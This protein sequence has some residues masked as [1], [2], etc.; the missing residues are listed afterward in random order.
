MN[1]LRI[2]AALLLCPIGGVLSLVLLSKHYG[3]PL[4]GEAVL[5]AC[6]QSGGCDIVDQSRFA[7][8]LGIPLAAWG[9]FF[10]GALVALLAPLLASD[11][12]GETDSE[13]SVAFC[14]FAAAVAIDAFL[15]GLQFVVIKAFCKFCIATYAVNLLGLALLWPFRSL[16]QLLGYFTAGPR[17]RAMAAWTVGVLA[18]AAAALAGNAALETRKALASA[19]ILGLPLAPAPAPAQ[20]SEAGSIEQQLSAARAEAKKWKDT[21][22]DEKRLQVY[23]TQ[24]AR[25]DFNQAPV[26]DLDLRRTPAKGKAGAPIKV[27]TY[28]DFMCPFCRD[29]ALGLR[30]YLPSSG[31]QVELYYKNF[32]LDT[33]CNSQIGRTVHQGACELA[34]G[35]ICA[36]ESGRFW[37][38]HDRVFAESWQS[39]VAKR[40]D[41]LRLGASAGLDAAKLGA[42]VAASS[43]RGRLTA[44]IEEGFRIGVGSTPTV[45][46]NGRRLGSSNVFLLAVDE[47]RKR[48]NL[49]NAATAAPTTK[50]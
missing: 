49:A 47:E 45:V 33:T 4:L 27:V 29:L 30:N 8:F 6:G 38:Y 9:L 48:L 41:V 44:E 2:G 21:L 13:L 36:A 19:S 26:L 31:D 25:N 17:R 35:G 46:V 16:S 14:L 50:P 37:E 32:P 20:L 7:R 24:K 22:D 12:P 18:V 3:I 34:L 1:K 28:S 40:E 23:L 42:C 43:T 39:G 11:S 15:F 5:A 10:Y